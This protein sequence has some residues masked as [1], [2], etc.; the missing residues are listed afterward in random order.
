MIY[1]L[2]Y[3]SGGNIVH[4]CGDPTITI[5]PLINRVEYKDANGNPLVDAS[6]APLSGS[7]H[8]MQE[9]VGIDQATH[10]MLIANGLD[11]YTY[12]NGAVVAKV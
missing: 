7:D 10:D 1:F 2:E 4:V 5:V 8:P 9:P 3:D 12:S 11:K 6:G